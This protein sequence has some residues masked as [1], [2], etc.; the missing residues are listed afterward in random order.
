MG[1]DDNGDCFIFIGILVA[2]LS[3]LTVSLL[4]LKVVSTQYGGS[5]SSSYMYLPVGLFKSTESV[6]YF[7]NFNRLAE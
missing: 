1:S 5:S 2:V 6:R 7:D 3:L 4:S